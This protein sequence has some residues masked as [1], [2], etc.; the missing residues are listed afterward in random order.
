MSE[1][2]LSI[3]VP[4]YNVREYLDECIT[5]ILNQTYRNLEVII[6]LDGP[7]DGS[8]E[9]CRRYAETDGRIKLIAFEKNRGPSFARSAGVEAASGKYL[10]FVDADDY[11]DPN[12]YQQLMECRGGF[13]LVISRW[14]REEGGKTRVSRDALPAGPYETEEDMEFILEHIVSITELGG[15]EYIRPGIF[16]IQFNKLYKTSSAKKIYAQT[17]GNMRIFEDLTFICL[18]ILTCRSVLI[19]DICGYHYRIRKTSTGHSFFNVD[20]YTSDVQSM[21]RVLEPVF[22][23]HPRRDILMPQLQRKVASL[24][25]RAP[26]KAGFCEEAQ[27]RTFVFP[28]FNLLDGKH[29]ALYGA[30]ETGQAYRRQIRRHGM[31]E[32]DI[33]V[34]EKWEYYRREGWD[35]SPVE[36]LANGTYDYVVI[37]AGRQDVADGIRERLA[38]MGTAA[39]KILWRA[40]VELF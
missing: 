7:T 11:I 26:R 19:T 21:Y 9:I 10:G 33:W 22:A 37:A 13:D 4:V 25:N 2:L 35:V 28:F 3:V 18:Y 6:V 39:D 12:F 23:A 15:G 24:L 36:A 30:G 31:C 34:D 27:N 8:D 17:A 14:K 5:S 40:P 32:V 29:I 16:P 1:E 20:R 38:A